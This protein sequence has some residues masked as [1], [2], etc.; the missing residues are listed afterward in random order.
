M[1]MML[2]RDG[3]KKTDRKLKPGREAAWS[4]GWNKGREKEKMASNTSEYEGYA[5][6]ER[7]EADED[8]L[9]ECQHLP[10]CWKKTL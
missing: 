3:W 7:V 6:C 4:P 2:A 8:L 1:D 5:V 9:R 10:G